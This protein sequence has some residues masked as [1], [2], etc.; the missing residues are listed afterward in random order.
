M[1]TL[2]AS[3]WGAVIWILAAALPAA[4]GAAEPELRLADAVRQALEGNL[5]LAARR[6]TLAAN[7]E[8]I[9]LARAPL[10]PQ[11]TVGARA[12]RLDDDRSDS[13]RGNTSE[14]STTLAAGATQVVYDETSRADL[15]IQRRVYA[16]QTQKFAGFRLAV[17]ED[18]ANAFLGLDRA[19]A[20]LNIQQRNRDITARNLETSRARIAA[21]WSSERELLRWQSQLAANDT[22]VVQARTQVLV[23]RFELNRVRNQPAEAPITSLPAT[24]EEYGFVYARKLIVDAIAEPEGD[25]RL[26][27]FLVRVGLKRSPQLAAIDEAIAAEERLLTANRRA[28]WVPSVSLDA[29]VDHL[30]ADDRSSGPD[31]DF[32]DTEWTLGASLV[33]PLFQGGAKFAAVRQASET[34]SGLRLERRA[35]TQDLDQSIRAAFAESSGSYANIAFARKEQDAASRNYE[36]VNKSY[37]LGVASILDLLDAQ[38]QLLN[39]ELAVMNATYDFLEDLISA[40]RQTA[41]FP[42]LEPEPEVTALLNRLEQELQSVP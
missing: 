41:F 9:D 30:A 19:R 11:I 25:R 16:A 35:A 10:L 32:R 15:Y 40:E 18:A 21:G 4:A 28:F 7:R 5:D 29:S 12:Q 6:R 17:I 24:S 22:A 33:F 13:N 1:R 27:D 39:A 14:N 38:T 31:D 37:V 8:E 20:S 36:L 3:R 2:R 26:R 23:T 34:L 42:F